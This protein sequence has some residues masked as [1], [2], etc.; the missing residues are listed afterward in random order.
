MKVYDG[1]EEF[2]KIDKAIVT[3][4]TFDGVHKGHQKILKKITSITK[5]VGGESV[6]L[7]FWPHPRMVLNPS[8]EL[9]LLNTFEEKVALIS[10]YGIDHL[11]KLEFTKEFSQMSS[12]DF[13]NNILVDA[14]GTR[15]LVI[16]YNHRFGKNREGGF[17][18]LKEN[19]TIFGFEVL[20]IPKHE[21]DEIGVSST[22]IRNSLKEGDVQKA[23]NLMGHPY[24]LEGNV[25]S[26]EKIG[27]LIGFPTA[28][29]LLNSTNKLI[30]PDGVY[31]VRVGIDNDNYKGMLYIGNRPT[32]DGKHKTIEVNI[33]D[34]EGEIYNRNIKVEFIKMLR[35]DM[36]FDNLNDLKKQLKLDQDESIKTLK[37]DS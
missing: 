37:N 14:I 9:F 32:L 31:V 34:F 10:R 33:F 8:Q 5:K 18:F 26:G 29:I 20:E 3:S 19:S 1:L 24:S 35:G 13:V 30:P 22:K 23:K 11:I 28:N 12:I 16:G 6:L 2:K 17:D 7:T 21:V 36:K 25:V 27:R 15:K 4:G